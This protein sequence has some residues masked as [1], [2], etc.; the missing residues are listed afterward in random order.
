MN[1]ALRRVLVVLILLAAG[2]ASA[3]G[4]LTYFALQQ[5]GQAMV[6]VDTDQSIAY[7]VDLGKSGDGDQVLLDGLPLLDRLHDLTIRRLVFECSHPHSDH[8]GGIVGLL[9]NDANFFPNGDRLNPRFESVTVIDDSSK[10]TLALLLAKL[11]K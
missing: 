2:S 5:A 4:S 1:L 8:M 11:A 9:S 10:D 7:I 3:V 6:A